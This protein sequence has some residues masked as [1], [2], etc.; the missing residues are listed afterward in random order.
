MEHQDPLKHTALHEDEEDARLSVIFRSVEAPAPPPQFAARTMNAVR[1]APL[2]AGRRPLR[3]PLAGLVGWA[4]L[5]A[6]VAVSS[7]AI[8]VTQPQFASMFTRLVSGG[9]G[10]GVWLMQFASAGLA[11]SDVFTTTGLAVTRAVVTREGSTGLVLISAMGAFSLSALHRLLISEGPE[12]GVSQW[13]E[14]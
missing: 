3:N 13:Q 9:I 11:L 14:L 6:G 7:W 10:V 4:A 5:I 8:A 1:R 2:P 12:K